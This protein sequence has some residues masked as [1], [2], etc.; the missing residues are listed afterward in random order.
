MKGG[1]RNTDEVN[2]LFKNKE[3]LELLACQMLGV[4]SPSCQDIS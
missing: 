3:Y 2:K 4:E 1:K